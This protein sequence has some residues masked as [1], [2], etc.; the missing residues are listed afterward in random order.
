M[1]NIGGITFN[2]DANATGAVQNI[3]IVV[4]QLNRLEREGKAAGKGLQ[5]FNKAW[6]FVTAAIAAAS[7]AIGT[8]K[9]TELTKESV[10]LAGRVESL[11]TV[12]RNLAKNA[13]LSNAELTLIENRVKSLGITTRQ[14]RQALAQMAQANLDMRDAAVLARIAQ[15]AAVIAG[16][17][18]SDAFERLVVS[19]Q[20]ND[21]RLLRNLGIVINLN[22]TYRRFSQ[23]TG[24]TAQSLTAL[25]KQTLVL[26]EVIEKGI[27]IQGT[28]EA[29]LQDV[30]K[31]FTSMTRL[32]EDAK[33]AYG[34]QFIPIFEQVVDI[35]SKW[36]KEIA[37][38]NHW[39][40]ELAGQITVFAVAAG[41]A[42]TVVGGLVAGL[43]GLAAL[44]AAG[45]LAVGVVAGVGALAAVLGL[46]AV[47][48][49]NAEQR[50]RALENSFTGAA[51][52]GSELVFL[53]KQQEEYIEELKQ[54]SDSNIDATEKGYRLKSMLGELAA[55]FPD[56]RFEIQALVSD[57]NVKELAQLLDKSFDRSVLD[58][59]KNA[60][61]NVLLLEAAFAKATQNIDTTEFEGEAGTVET[62]VRKLTETAG[63]GGPLSDVLNDIVFAFSESDD[64][65]QQW[66]DTIGTKTPRELDKLKR[67][68]QA[69]G[70]EVLKGE[71][72]IRRFAEKATESFG[73][74][75]AADLVAK[76]NDAVR[77]QNIALGAETYITSRI[78]S[79]NKQRI[80][81][82]I[83]FKTQALEIQKQSTAE[84]LK[85]FKDSG[86]KQFDEVKENAETARDFVRITVEEIR[87]YYDAL[88]KTQLRSQNEFSDKAIAKLKDRLSEIED[89]KNDPETDAQE[90][91][92]LLEEE[93]SLR[94]EIL[95]LENHRLALQKNIREENEL[96]R[97][98][99]EESLVAARDSVGLSLKAIDDLLRREEAQ[100]AGIKKQALVFELDLDP[101]IATVLKRIEETAGAYEIFT[102]GAGERMQPLVDALNEL[103][104]E[105]ANV[106]NKQTALNATD[107]ERIKQIQQMIQFTQDLQTRLE[108]LN[109]VRREEYEVTQKKLK[110]DARNRL[111]ASLEDVSADLEGAIESL[112]E[113][114][115]NDDFLARTFEQAKDRMDALTRS[116]ERLDDFFSKWALSEQPDAA[117]E[118]ISGM[119]DDLEDFK[120]ALKGVTSPEQLAKL[121][122]LFPQALDQR[123]QALRDEIARLKGEVSGVDFLELSSGENQAFN[124]L[125]NDGFSPQQATEILQD[126]ER[127]R[128]DK[129]KDKVKPLE[130]ALSAALRERNDLEKQY[131]EEAEK[132]KAVI[133]D[134]V[135]LQERYT[136][137]LDEEIEK[138]RQI[139]LEAVAAAEKLKSVFVG[140]EFQGVFKQFEGTFSGAADMLNRLNKVVQEVAKYNSFSGLEANSGKN[141]A[142]TDREVDAMAPSSG[143][144]EW[145]ANIRNEE[146]HKRKLQ[147]LLYSNITEFKESI[148]V[149][150]DWLIEVNQAAR[151]AK[152]TLRR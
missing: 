121:N 134:R 12:L 113:L 15:D 145:V 2:I 47:E 126:R 11:G 25:E 34:D 106:T 52:E 123:I 85:V 110:L 48:A 141:K 6:G 49:F 43:A 8:L 69:L 101:A 65:A 30:Y 53:A 107:N 22:N 32:V 136:E 89:E 24:R 64:A 143:V 58:R 137:L 131:V 127:E 88:T 61:N 3:K 57:G 117:R 144:Q 51:S 80:E 70:F 114:T 73:S 76:L 81:G 79:E 66:A 35:T 122:S 86:L 33:V 5:K 132:T 10:L 44:F 45:P 119:R 147:D 112:A 55:A 133:A 4:K 72:T 148:G 31:R 90:R 54:L 138:Q 14:T 41:A 82:L 108:R 92:T 56:L 149:I 120:E 28:Y 100:T 150:V 59:I 50:L 27:L 13:G 39:F 91:L 111:K 105:L 124:N 26:N 125:V 77:E 118:A 42:V 7:S 96:L 115:G 130:D 142:A 74:I 95:Q 38:P 23:E 67:E 78:V 16:I 87:G 93:K 18:S 129:N 46:F 40:T 140:E 63:F 29:S 104:L 139:G 36:L 68:V 128:Q 62:A 94:A 116:S 71:K 97:E 60:S 109:D 146:D 9:L 84:R 103:N 19:I 99:A 135:G 21:V 75:R 102:E 1:I 37:K 83:N 152:G 17:N 151:Q 98:S 20:R